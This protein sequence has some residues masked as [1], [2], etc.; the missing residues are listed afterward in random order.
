M[1]WFCTRALGL[2]LFQIFLLNL[3]LIQTDQFEMVI[4]TDQFEMVI[5]T[6]QFEMVIQTDQFEMVI[7]ESG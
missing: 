1:C 4:Q 6:D 5:Q 7:C 2:I 3:L